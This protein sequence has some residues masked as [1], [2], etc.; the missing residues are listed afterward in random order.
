MSMGGFMRVDRGFLESTDKYEY[1][2]IYGYSWE[3]MVV[4]GQI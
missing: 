3:I 1:A 4:Y 2:G